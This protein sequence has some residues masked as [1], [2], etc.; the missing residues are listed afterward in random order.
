MKT[1]L[2]CTLAAVVALGG[3][4]RLQSAEKQDAGPSSAKERLIG[5]WHLVSMEEQGA[6][7]KVNRITDRK[8]MLIYTRDGHMSVQLMLPKSESGVSNDYVQNGYEASF[9]SYDL[10]EQAHTVTHHV[11]GSVTRRLVGK[12]LPRV[13]Q[14]SER[15][16]II[17][18][19]RPEEHWSVVWEHY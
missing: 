15:Q 11:Q 12:D 16:L 10:D 13:F 9:G 18:S 19:T 5:A 3:L 17:R 7:G 14:I 1:L 6:D 4:S 8:G 2:G